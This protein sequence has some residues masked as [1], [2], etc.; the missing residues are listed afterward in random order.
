MSFIEEHWS[1]LADVIMRYRLRDTGFVQDARICI[2]DN[3]QGFWMQVRACHKT[4][5]ERNWTWK[6]IKHTELTPLTASHQN[7]DYPWIIISGTNDVGSYC[8]AI[9]YPKL[10]EDAATTDL[11]FLVA[12]A[13]VEVQGGVRVTIVD[14]PM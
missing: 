13:R 2:K 12:L 3:G 10:A 11:F 1:V 7:K 9:C 6:E 8:K 4:E 14:E 5:S